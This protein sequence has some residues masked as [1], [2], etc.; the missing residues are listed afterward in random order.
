MWDVDKLLEDLFF[1]MV[2]PGFRI[3]ITFAMRFADKPATFT[4][5]EWPLN[6]ADAF[7]SS[8]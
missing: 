1:F 2:L 7:Y 5:D 8:A 4:L 6:Q 3:C